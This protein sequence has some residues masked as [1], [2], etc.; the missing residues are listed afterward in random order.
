[1]QPI[2]LFPGTLRDWTLTLKDETP[3]GYVFNVIERLRPS[4]LESFSLL[5]LYKSEKIGKDRKN[6]T[7][8]FVYRSTEKT[9]S[10]EEVES[11]HSKLIAQMEEQLKGHILG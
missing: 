5:D 4:L 8:R 11:I 2:G 9:L 10:F 1:M 3:I 6:I 7:L